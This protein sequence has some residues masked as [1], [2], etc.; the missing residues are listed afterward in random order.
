MQIRSLRLLSYRS[1]KVDDKTYVEEVDYRLGKL[2]NFQ[3][4]RLEGCS[5]KT[6]LQV[7]GISRALFLFQDGLFHMMFF[8][9]K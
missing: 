9:N 5:E 1:W 7:L 6:A 4:L 2:N 3:Q 8:T